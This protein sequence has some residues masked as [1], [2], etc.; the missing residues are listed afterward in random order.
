M[1]LP[2]L[3]K[4]RQGQSAAGGGGRGGT[5]GRAAAGRGY[6]AATAAALHGPT[7]ATVAAG[8]SAAGTPGAV[9]IDADG[10]GGVPGQPAGQRSIRCGNCHV[11]QPRPRN[12]LGPVEQRQKIGGFH[13]VA[14]TL[15]AA[16]AAVAASHT[17]TRQTPR[18]HTCD[19]EASVCAT[20]TRTC[21]WG[22]SRAIGIIR[23]PQ[24]GAS[25]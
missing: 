5:A 20:S 2:A 23:C 8:R 9:S 3:Q 1:R 7:G 11:P 21:T 12:A 4:L 19:P 6:T 14:T 18:V 24:A 16:A 13:G 15:R 25:T 22:R 17:C 10:C